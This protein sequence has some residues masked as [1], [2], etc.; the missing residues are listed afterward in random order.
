MIDLT[1]RSEGCFEGK[2]I[3]ANVKATSVMTLLNNLMIL[4]YANQERGCLVGNNRLMEMIAA[5]DTKIVAFQPPCM[6][7]DWQANQISQFNM[8]SPHTVYFLGDDLFDLGQRHEADDRPKSLE[9]ATLA[10]RLPVGSLLHLWEKSGILAGKIRFA[11]Y[12]VLTYLISDRAAIEISKHYV[13][14]LNV[15]RKMGGENPA[16]CCAR[17]DRH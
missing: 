9:N 12:R 11:D 13:E 2:T 15:V 4:T 10:S 8:T 3:Q 1:N 17:V 6:P 5:I 14:D 16:H 7:T